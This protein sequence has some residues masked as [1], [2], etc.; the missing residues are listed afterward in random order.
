MPREVFSKQ[1]S[2]QNSS[3]KPLG[4]YRTLK[5]KGLYSLNWRVFCNSNNMVIIDAIDPSP[6]MLFS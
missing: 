1:N 2:K 6:E 3:L 5:W 4:L